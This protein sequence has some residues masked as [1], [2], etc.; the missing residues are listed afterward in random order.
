MS[1][2]FCEEE[3]DV[4]CFILKTGDDQESSQGDECIT[5]PA[6]HV[7]SREVGQTST[8]AV[9]VSLEVNRWNATKHLVDGQSKLLDKGVL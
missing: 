8:N 3:N 7:A 4:T 9:F 6:P 2:D 1:H 5:A